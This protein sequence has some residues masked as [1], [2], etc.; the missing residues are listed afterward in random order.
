MIHGIYN[1]S[2]KRILAQQVEFDPEQLEQVEFGST[3]SNKPIYTENESYIKVEDDLN[4]IH[5]WIDYFN[6]ELETVKTEVYRVS[7]PTVADLPPSVPATNEVTRT[8]PTE[9]QEK[10]PSWLNKMKDYFTNPATYAAPL[11]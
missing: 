10:K 2:F 7:E 9:Q 5:E 8:Q 1:K 11:I 6:N 4:S 3:P